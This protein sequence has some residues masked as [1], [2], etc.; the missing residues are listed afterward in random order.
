MLSNYLFIDT[1]MPELPLKLELSR[2]SRPDVYLLLAPFLPGGVVLGAVMLRNWQLA[3]KIIYSHFLGYYTKITLLA[4]AAYFLGFLVRFISE[5]ISREVSRLL[6]KY[7]PV[8][9]QN[10]AFRPWNALEWRRLARLFIGPKLTPETD[11]PLDEA[12]YQQ[13]ALAIEQISNPEQKRSQA[14]ELAR[15]ADALRGA[16]LQWTNWYFILRNYINNEEALK[17]DLFRHQIIFLFNA[18]GMA[19]IIALILVPE[20]RNWFLWLLF[21]STVLIGLVFPFAVARTASTWLALDNVMS[22]QMLKIIREERSKEGKTAS[23]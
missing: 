22:A 23:T 9:K 7:V 20:A 8:E 11:F 19:G 18:C 15:A 2:M 4:L 13:L 6:L 10:Q 17:D 21:S 14:E 16:D 5:A 3:S 1:F 12:R